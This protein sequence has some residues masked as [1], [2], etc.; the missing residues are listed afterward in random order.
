M[1]VMNFFTFKK[2]KIKIQNNKRLYPPGLCVVVMMMT[3]G[4]GW[5]IYVYFLESRFVDV[6]DLTEKILLS[7]AGQLAKPIRGV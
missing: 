2:I 4:R 1:M 6:S 7:E 3:I 5:T